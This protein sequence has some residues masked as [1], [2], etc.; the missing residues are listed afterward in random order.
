MKAVDLFCG[1]GGLSLGFEKVG[2]DIAAAYDYWDA[3]IACYKANFTHPIFKEDLSD[4]DNMVKKIK[5]YS[6]DIVIGGPPC[7]DFSHAGKRNEG[8][9]ADLTKSF[10][11]IV[12]TTSPEWFV[13]ENVDRMQNSKA[14]EAARNAFKEAGYGLNERVLDASYCGVPQKRKRFFCIG[15]LGAED[16]FLDDMFENALSKKPM[17]IRNYLGNILCVEHYYRH[18]RNYS[19]RAVFSIDE[20]SPTVRGVNRPIPAGYTGHKGDP[21]TVDGLRCLT[22]KERSLIQTFP[23]KFKLIG[24]KTDIEQMIG[25][26]VPVNLARFVG[27]IIINYI[28]EEQENAA[29][30][31]RMAGTKHRDWVQRAS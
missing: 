25:N 20:P 17:T 1:C 27:G 21:V 26:A 10:A 4:T 3:A 5:K 13:M 19:R 9:R 30:F 6:P 28:K 12:T 23:K 8:G 2:F 29:N 18:P 16:G 7:Q 14:Y 24:S 31:L 11:V 15:K 22:T